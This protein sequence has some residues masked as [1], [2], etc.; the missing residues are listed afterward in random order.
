MNR[1]IIIRAE[2]FNKEILSFLAEVGADMPIGWDNEVLCRVRN[3]VIEVY[4]KMGVTLEI[5]ERDNKSS[6]TVFLFP[7]FR[8]PCSER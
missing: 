7:A 2:D 5:D 8:S 4:E 3:T 1:K 6:N